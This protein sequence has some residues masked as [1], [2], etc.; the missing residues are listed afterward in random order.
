MR[1][2]RSWLAVAVLLIP[3]AA[4]ADDHRADRFGGF[5]RAGGSSLFG[6]H[7]TDAI[8]LPSRGMTNRD[9]ALLG[10][11]SV[12][13]GSRTPGRSQGRAD[14]QHDVTRITFLGGLRWT[15]AKDVADR[16]QQP[17]LLPFV[18]GLLGGVY[19][20]D[21]ANDASIAGGVGGGLD[22]VLR[23]GEPREAWA[24]RVQVD[25]IVSGQE[26]F[27]RVSAG[28]VYRFR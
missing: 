26:D 13:V 9:L 23:R 24:T 21:R 18:H 22:Y 11:L 8:T 12:H 7:V 3:A 20:H 6:V 14:D 17:K 27:V 5:S 2:Q 19:T 1:I 4:R 16:Q 28:I 25:Y 15:F 10:D